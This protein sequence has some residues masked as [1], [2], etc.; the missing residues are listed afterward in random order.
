MFHVT[1]ESEKQATQKSFPR[2]SCAAIPN[3][4]DVPPRLHAKD[5]KPGGLLR[6]LYIGRLDPK[7][8]LENLFTAI[9]CF[10]NKHLRLT[11]C[12]TG[13]ENYVAAL[14]ALAVAKG[15]ATRVIF[16]GHVDGPAK[17]AAF[18]D[19]DVT[20]LPSHSENFGIVVAESLAHSVPIVTSTATPWA[21]VSEKRCGWWIDN[22]ARSL[23]DTIVQVENADLPSMGE[24]G[25][26]WMEEEFAWQPI[27]AEMERLYN[28]VAQLDR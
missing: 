23:V 12:G 1:S 5:W 9:A 28:R 15:I 26:R 27:A 2:V 8:G 10:K 21:R 25:R 13:D 6:L 17:S 3:G 16:A 19:A 14:R 22:S 20:V 4:V 7:K 24:Q 18:A 11:V